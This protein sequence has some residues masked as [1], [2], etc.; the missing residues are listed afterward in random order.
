MVRSGAAR[1]VA[2]LA[3]LLVPVTSGAGWAAEPTTRPGPR[4]DWTWEWG[5]EFT[6]GGLPPG[7]GPYQGLPNA[8]SAAWADSQ[9]VVGRGALRLTLERRATSGRPWTSGGIGC[10]SRIQT[11]GRYEM[12]ARVPAGR[13]IETVLVLQAG[14]SDRR[15]RAAIVLSGGDPERITVVDGDRTRSLPGRYSDTMHTYVLQWRPEGTTV[16]VDGEVVWS[17]DRAFRGPRWFGLLLRTAGRGPEAGALPATAVVD[18]LAVHRYTPGR[19]GPGGL[20]PP[21]PAPSLSGTA[22]RPGSPSASVPA[23]AS[24]T[25]SPSPM[26]P[27]P[28]SSTSPAG[29]GAAEP[30]VA[31]LLPAGDSELPAWPWALVGVLA[32]A[33][34]LVGTVRAALRRPTR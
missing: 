23:S 18:A 25:P 17:G 9:V 1:V 12:R 21:P 20:A 7:C 14:D 16:L 11:Y 10:L 22:S 3:V 30:P 29:A 8:R 6:D 15:S 32:G 4:G 34:V 31:A 19:G 2:L 24:P 28:T 27:S 5:G 26:P 33:A 13:G